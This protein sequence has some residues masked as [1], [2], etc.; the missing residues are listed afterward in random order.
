MTRPR[1]PSALRIAA[2]AVLAWSAAACADKGV[3]PLGTAALADS[4]DMMMLGMEKGIFENGVRRAVIMADTAWTYQDAQRMELGN[5]RVT[6]FDQ[7]GVQ[8]SVLTAAQGTYQI[9]TESLDARGR[10]LLVGAGGERLASPRLSYDKV[11][12]LV[13]SDTTFTYES[14]NQYLQGN[15]FVS[16]PEFKA[17]R[18]DQPRGRQ[19]TGGILLPGQTPP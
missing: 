14:P 3:T 12:N 8:T 11:A 1:N 7:G 10:V 16:D 6:F 19:R 5:L 9:Q 2:V 17:P 15:S 4:A 13:S 18:V